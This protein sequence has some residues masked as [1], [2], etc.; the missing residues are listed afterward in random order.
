[1][2]IYLNE[3]LD[4]SEAPGPYDFYLFT[5]NS[6]VT[7]DKRLVM[8]RGAAKQVRDTYNGID[9][10]FGYY[11]PHLQGYGVIFSDTWRI[12]VFQVKYHFKDQADS[13]L[14]ELSCSYLNDLC[15]CFPSR[16]FH[17]NYPGIGNGRRSEEDMQV[18]LDE[19]LTEDNIRIY[20]DANL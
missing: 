18:I 17:M 5:G 2:P 3:R 20:K 19:L 13:G 8:G 4:Y 9:A 16:T 14:I 10:F 15:H 11:V 6:Y 1:M 12:G 7:N